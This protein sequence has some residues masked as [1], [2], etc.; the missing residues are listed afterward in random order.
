APALAALMLVA[1]AAAALGSALLPMPAQAQEQEELREQAEQML[2]RDLDDQEIMDMLRQSGMT[3]QQIRDRLRERGMDPSAA[4]P[5]LD[6]LEGRASDVP[7]GTSPAPIVSVLSGSDAGRAAGLDTSRVGRV[8]TDSLRRRE[9][10]FGPPVFGREIFRR[11]TSQF[12]PQTTGPVPPDYRVGPGDQLVL[13]LTGAVEQAYE[14]RVS[15]EGWVVVPEVG[16]VTVNGRTVDELRS[17]MRDR[18]AQSYSSLKGENPSTSFDLT[19]GELRTNQVYVIGEVERPASYNVSSLATALSALYRA[20][21]PTRNGSFREVRVNRGGE[22]VATLDLYEYLVEGKSDQDVR[23]QQGDIIFVPVARRQ[24]RVEGPVTRPAIYE[25]EE[26]EEL[27]DLLRYAG[28]VEPQADLRRVQ[29][30]RILSPAERAP[31]R[32]RRVID[33]AVGDLDD[34]QDGDVPLMDGDRIQVF[35]VADEA[36]N[37]VTVSG[38]VWRPGTYG[39][40]E[41]S[42]LWDAVE[43]AGG[44]LPDA[45]EARAQIQRLDEET[46]TRR[47]IHVSL[48]R[49][50]DGEPEENPRLEGMDQVLIY[51]RRNLRD[52]ETVTVGGWVREPGTYAWAEGMTVADLILKAGGVREGAYTAEAEVARPVRS[53]QRT[54]TLARE[55]TVSLDSTY[56]FEAGSPP[57][58]ELGGEAAGFEV[59]PRDAVYV[60]KAPGYEERRRVV[61]TGEVQ[62]P[63]PYTVGTRGERLTDLLEEAGGVTDEAYVEGFQLWRATDDTVSRGDSLL[64]TLRRDTAALVD[65]IRRE[66]QRQRLRLPGERQDTAAEQEGR[67]A[68]EDTLQRQVAREDS[69]LLELVKSERRL[70][71]LRRE[72]ARDRGETMDEPLATPVDSALQVASRVRVGVDFDRA[73]E[74]PGGRENVLVEPGDSVHVPQYTPTVTVRGAVGVETKV[75][76]REGAGLD[77]YVEQ[78][79]GYLEQA[80]EDRVWVRFANGEVDTKGGGFLFFGGGV[81]D[82]DP[83]ATVNVPYQPPEERGEGVTFNDLIPIIT[84]V[85][86]TITTIVVATN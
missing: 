64:R 35:A 67:I 45:V 4:D 30:H 29:I 49:G 32:D 38:A 79:G 20:G 42:R 57:P 19:L 65:S 73:L 27:R 34:P 77:Y 2:G 28:G 50:P 44:L 8:P 70:D 36:R 10:E 33:V 41:D 25:V 37:R 46:D 71:S 39:A 76:W 47:M 69:L 56:V 13:V 43:A 40:G 22:T 14:L 81:S 15:R 78:A 11:A 5:W 7:E 75:L 55:H 58:E 66:R 9:P 12:E 52:R 74:N 53:Q 60:R 63:G 3:P 59:E 21:G 31:G 68:A 51:A 48:A 62:Y 82:P 6:V 61:I 85:L 80:D 86:G 18:L 24:V 23:L 54:D 16:R 1:T 83:G 26:G 72:R 17:V 84:S